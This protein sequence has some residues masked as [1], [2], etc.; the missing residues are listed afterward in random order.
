[1]QL[2]QTADLNFDGYLDLLMVGYANVPHLGNTFYCAWL[3]QPQG[4]RFKEVPEIGEI[5]DPTP[6]PPTKT[7]RS[8]RDYLGGPEVDET[9]GWENG[10]LV[11]LESKQRFYSSSVE[12]CGEYTIEVRKNGKMEKVK[13]DIVE[14]G[15]DEIIPCN[16]VKKSP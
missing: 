14:S 16:S 3:W 12:G 9:Y 7:I 11:L 8:H 4:G 2:L 6:D 5:S 10:K 13:D 1:L 15:V